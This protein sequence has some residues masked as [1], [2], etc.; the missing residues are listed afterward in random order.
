MF[1]IIH[2]P[3]DKFTSYTNVIFS[4][5]KEAKEFGS[6]CIKK[7]I[8]WDVVLYNKENYDKYWYK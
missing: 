7:K 5:E 6:K 4:T 2:K 3:K 1:F 8:E